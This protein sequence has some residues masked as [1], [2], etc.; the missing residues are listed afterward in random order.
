MNHKTKQTLKKWAFKLGD[1]KKR[2][3]ATWLT[4]TGQKQ[5]K[6]RCS[7]SDTLEF[8]RET[9]EKDMKMKQ[10]ERAERR[11]AQQKITVCCDRLLRP[12]ELQ[13]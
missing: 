4:A 12:F 1:S 10:E 7:G 13:S 8:M 11:S 3:E 5:T 2:R 6:A 9:L